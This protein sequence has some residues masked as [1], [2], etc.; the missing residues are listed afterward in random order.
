MPCIFFALHLVYGTEQCLPRRY[1]LFNLHRPQAPYHT[2]RQGNSN[3]PADPPD[4]TVPAWYVPNPSALPQTG[5]FCE[6]L[7][8]N[9][10][11]V[12]WRTADQRLYPCFPLGATVGCATGRA[13]TARVSPAAT[14]RSNNSGR[15]HRSLRW[16]EWRCSP[17]LLLYG[18]RSPRVVNKPLP[19]PTP[20]TATPSQPSAADRSRFEQQ[21][22]LTQG[23]VVDRWKTS[24][25]GGG[26]A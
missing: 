22:Q 12:C 19:I 2:I 10:A 6:Y 25:R 13:R 26:Y 9:R 21:G 3:E 20:L 17:H 4:A 23:R 14:S 5:A 8:G 1:L 11:D 16:R 15:G 7:A 18:R 24:K